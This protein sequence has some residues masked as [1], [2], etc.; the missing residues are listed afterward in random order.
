VP[1]TPAHDA[2][3]TTPDSGKDAGVDSA[4]SSTNDDCVGTQSAQIGSSYDEACD[5][6]W[7]N[8]LGESNPCT[9]GGKTCAPLDTAS[10]KFCCYK[11]PPG[12]LCALDY[13]TPQCLPK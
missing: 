1:D 9:P 5:N 7:F 11:P 13:N 8:T 2:S 3:T 12:T 10:M 4:V 6:Y